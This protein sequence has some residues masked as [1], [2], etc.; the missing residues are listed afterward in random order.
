M[1]YGFVS[2][3]IRVSLLKSGP[4]SRAGWSIDEILKID[5]IVEI[6]LQR[7]EGAAKI[8]PVGCS[9]IRQALDFLILIMDYEIPDVSAYWL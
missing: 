2:Y 4:N 1:G 7:I 6:K 8:L 9:Y 3:K 5:Q